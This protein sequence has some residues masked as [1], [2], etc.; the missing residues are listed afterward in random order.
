VAVAARPHLE[1]A[2]LGRPGERCPLELRPEA[3]PARAG[4]DAERDHLRLRERLAAQADRRQV[5]VGADVL[6]DEA[7]EPDDLGPVQR[8]QHVRGEVPVG[9]EPQV[10]RLLLAR[11]D[12]EELREARV[13]RRPALDEGRGLRPP[14]GRVH[15][16]VAPLARTAAHAAGRSAAAKLLP[17]PAHTS[18]SRSATVA[19]TSAKLARVPSSLPG[20]PG[21]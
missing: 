20:T 9:G 12:V 13:L 7:Q 11:H 14:P 16:P 10:A 3:A 5:V 8:D 17:G 6:D 4:Y 15:L 19:P 21:A 1:A 2:E 18:P